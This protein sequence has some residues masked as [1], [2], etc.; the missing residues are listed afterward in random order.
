MHFWLTAPWIS[1]SMGRFASAAQHSR[2]TICLN[3][4]GN[5]SPHE[6]IHC[7]SY[8]DQYNN[9]EGCQQILLPWQFCP[10]MAHLRLCNGSH[11]QVLLSTILLVDSGIN[12]GTIGSHLIPRRV[13][14]ATVLTTSVQLQDLDVRHTTDKRTDGDSFND[15]YDIPA[16]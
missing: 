9:A 8:S 7:S 14:N 16:T 13:Y 10:T 3:N 2:H 15:A 4:Q 12:T 5:I 1:L 6:S 11:K